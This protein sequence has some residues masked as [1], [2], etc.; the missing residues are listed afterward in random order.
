MSS[1]T[2]FMMKLRADKI[3]KMCATIQT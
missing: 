2:T 3:W 1:I